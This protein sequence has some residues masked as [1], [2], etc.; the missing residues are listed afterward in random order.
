M[1]RRGDQLPHSGADEKRKDN[2]EK[3]ER[4]KRKDLFLATINKRGRRPDQPE[5]K[6][7]ARELVGKG[8]GH[9]IVWSLRIEYFKKRISALLR[10]TKRE[11]LEGPPPGERLMRER[12]STVP[13]R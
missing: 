1:T 3:R 5:R 2:R 4:I 10:E 13:A 9:Q 12:G 8:V 7:L 11:R 6:K